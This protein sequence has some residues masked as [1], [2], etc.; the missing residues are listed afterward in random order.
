MGR[1]LLLIHPPPWLKQAVSTVTA[2]HN[3]LAHPAST[4]EISQCRHCKERL[5]GPRQGLW[6]TSG[7]L[8]LKRAASVYTLQQNKVGKR[9]KYLRSPAWGYLCN[10]WR[11]GWMQQQ[12]IEEE[13]FTE[14]LWGIQG[15]CFVR[16]TST[17][18]REPFAGTRQAPP[19]K[20]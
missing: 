15:N 12:D 4:S 18:G 10:L 6:V 19:A 9:G 20:A 11:E 5:P 14:T 16:R 3:L 8:S 17:R 7:S 2:S 1:K 13:L